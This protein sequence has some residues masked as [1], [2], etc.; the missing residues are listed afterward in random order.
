MSAERTVLLDVEDLKMHFQ[1]KG[2]D[3]FG[4]KTTLK[5]VDGVSFKIYEGEALG[6]VGESGCGKTTV[7]KMI[8]KLLQPTG[9]DMLYRGENIVGLNRRQFKK[10]RQEIQIIFQDPF[11]SLDPRQSIGKIIGEPLRAKK[12]KGNIPEMVKQ[13]MEDVGLR[14]D[15]YTRY[16]HEFSGGQRQRVGVARA[17]ALNPTLVICDE[18]VSALDVSIQAQILNLM[19]DLQ[20]KYQ[21]TYL[22]ISHDMSVVK[23][24]CERIAIMYLG[25]IVEIAKTKLLFDSPLHPYTRALLEAIP[26]P[27]PELKKELGTLTGDVP[28]PINLPPGCRFI[29]RCSECMDKCETEEPQLKEVSP[30]HF[31]ECHLY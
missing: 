30:G 29:T 9:G 7:G 18:P 28:S 22:F 8:V 17:L 26:V 23:H 1:V 4:K 24:M 10:Y 16:P 21:L 20:E 31:V 3:A 15:S 14:Q 6:L 5:A 25:R 2:E 27:N 12:V 13:L 19:Q 11:S